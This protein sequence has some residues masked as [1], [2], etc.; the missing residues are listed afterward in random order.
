MRGSMGL[1]LT[2]LTASG[3][4]S[5]R[6]GYPAFRQQLYCESLECQPGNFSTGQN[7]ARGHEAAFET[8]P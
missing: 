1:F 4:L 3:V 5:L 2:G 8:E 7:E 6:R